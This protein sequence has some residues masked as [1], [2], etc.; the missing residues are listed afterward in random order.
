MRSIHIYLRNT[1][2]ADVKIFLTEAFPL[3]EAP[4]W[5]YG[6]DGE[7]YLYIQFNPYSKTEHEPQEWSDLVQNLGSEPAVILMADVSGRHAGDEQVK[8]FI[9]IILTTFEGVAQDDYSLHYWSLDEILSGHKIQGHHFF[10]YQG[11][12]EQKTTELH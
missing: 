9:Q 4:P 3:Q 8:Q 10:D 2:Q 5:V 1:N 12:F 11:W 7:A 6:I